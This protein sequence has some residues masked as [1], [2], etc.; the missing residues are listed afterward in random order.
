MPD[1]SVFN[2]LAARL[3]S[4]LYPVGFSRALALMLTGKVYTADSPLLSG[5]FHEVVD[6]QKDVLPRALELASEMASLNSSV[7]MAMVK[8]LLW[9]GANTPEEQHLLDSKGMFSLGNSVDGKEG[10]A[11]F[12]QKRPVR[13]EGF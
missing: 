12:M 13:N 3:P 10:V 2:D 1:F 7:S 11:S 9:H 8:G 6:Q 5:L 4:T